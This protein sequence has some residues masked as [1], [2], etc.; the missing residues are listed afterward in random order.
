[1]Q[2]I[3]HILEAV[4]SDHNGDYV[5]AAELYVEGLRS[6]TG[7]A[8]EP[9]ISGRYNEYI[10]RLVEICSASPEADACITRMTAGSAPVSDIPGDLPTSSGFDDL[11]PVAAGPMSEIV[12]HPSI[13]DIT[14][15]VS[16]DDNFLMSCMLD[17]DEPD[18]RE[19]PAPLQPPLSFAHPTHADVPVP[20]AHTTQIASGEVAASSLPWA[21]HEADALRAW[22][23]AQSLMAVC[24]TTR[25]VA[26]MAKRETKL[27][28]ATEA[29]MA[30][31]AAAATV[32]QSA[33]AD[34]PL[35]ADAEAARIRATRAAAAA[36]AQL[37]KLQPQLA[38]RRAPLGLPQSSASAAAAGVTGK[39]ALVV[40]SGFVPG[41]SS[42]RF[43]GDV[44][45]PSD[46]AG[47]RALGPAA[48]RPPQP[49][50]G[51]PPP[52][53]PP[54]MAGG[55]VGGGAVPQTNPLTPD[56]L[57]T[58]TSRESGTVSGIRLPLWDDPGDGVAAEVVWWK[59][60]Q[61]PWADDPSAVA[62]VV[63]P[64]D[65]RISLPQ[66][67]AGAA[68]P[69]QFCDGDLPALA[70][71]MLEARAAWRRPS[72]FL[73]AGVKVTV[74]RHTTADTIVQ[75]VV[76]DCSFVCSV[77]VASHYEGLHGG[78]IL[79]GAIYPQ[80][81]SGRPI[82]SPTGRYA[83]K[84]LVNGATRKV[85]VDD[86][87]PVTDDGR[88]LCTHSSVVQVPSDGGGSDRHAV[89]DL[90]VSLYEKA[91][92][93]VHGNSY[94]FPGSTSSV[95]LY[96]LA[97]WLPEI[98]PL[99]YA[100]PGGADITSAA[101]AAGLPEPPE[102]AGQD[103][104]PPAPFT[105]DAWSVALW[106]RLYA[107]HVRGDGIYTLNTPAAWKETD[108]N[109]RAVDVEKVLGLVDG[110]AYALLEM[111]EFTL[112]PP[113]K[114]AETYRLV[115]VKNP[116]TRQ[117][118]L[119]RFSHRDMLSWPA[120]LAETLDVARYRTEEDKGVF[121]I[122]WSDVCR[123]FSRLHASWNPR[124]KFCARVVRH[125]VLV[126]KSLDNGH[127]GRTSQLH[128]SVHVPPSYLPPGY[129]AALAEA[130]FRGDIPPP[131][132]RTAATS[133]A[134][135]T[136]PSAGAMAAAI[137][138][139]TS[140]VPPI[141]PI[142]PP[143]LTAWLLLSTHTTDGVVAAEAAAVAAGLSNRLYST[144][145]LTDN[146]GR[147][148]TAAAD[149]AR[150]EERVRLAS[151]VATQAQQPADGATAPARG[152]TSIAVAGA[153]A[154]ASLLPTGLTITAPD[155]IGRAAVCG[156]P[157]SGQSFG[158]AARGG[159]CLA[160]RL[161]HPAPAT[162][163][164]HWGTFRNTTHYLVPNI[165]LH[166]GHNDFT[167]VIATS[168]CPPDELRLP[169]TLTLY[170]PRPPPV[171]T[172]G[173]PPSPYLTSPTS[174]IVSPSSPS[175]VPRLPIA[176][177]LH[178]ISTLSFHPFTPSRDIFAFSRPAAP[179]SAALPLPPIPPPEAR[180][181]VVAAYQPVAAAGSD[182]A[183]CGGGADRRG[184]FHHNPQWTVTVP[185]GGARVV[186]S[187]EYAPVPRPRAGPAGRFAYCD[188]V[189][190]VTTR[191]AAVVPPHLKNV[192]AGVAVV[193]CSATESSFGWTHPAAAQ[194]AVVAPAASGGDVAPT[195][196]LG[197]PGGPVHP[198][199]AG[200]VSFIR[201]AMA[202]M[203]GD[204]RL[205]AG[206]AHGGSVETVGVPAVYCSNG[207]RLAVID[208]LDSRAAVWQSVGRDVSDA[209]SAA[210]ASM[211][212]L[213]PG[214][215]TVAA[216]ISSVQDLTAQFIIESDVGVITDGAAGGRV[217]GIRVARI[218]PEGSGA[219]VKGLS[220]FFQSSDASHAP[221]VFHISSEA[222]AIYLRAVTDAL[223]AC[224]AGGDTSPTSQNGNARG[225][226]SSRAGL[227]VIT[228]LIPAAE[229]LRAETNEHEGAAPLP[230]PSTS[231]SVIFSRG[232][233]RTVW[234]GGFRPV[235]GGLT[236]IVRVKGA[237][238]C[239]GALHA[240][241]TGPLNVQHVG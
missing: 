86:R 211:P 167:A 110:H 28:A 31:A 207:R 17:A 149:T 127:W 77:A 181:V 227:T 58:L 117:R 226:S 106:Q 119:G 76:S 85:V 161:F 219:G 177:A 150:A 224:D 109:G 172:A 129:T 46:A 19:L 151:L 122:S 41:V 116:W 80:D 13:V 128:V 188:E 240:W 135:S 95:D 163:L 202:G 160:R 64:N 125:G 206:P 39:G 153:A 68:P 231:G 69:Q 230:P 62:A 222:A 239:I 82:V 143:V 147:A 165:P 179:P 102:G 89:F 234:G 229:A 111:R 195:V 98:V 27:M 212:R 237:D 83:V 26:T 73:P 91:F 130:A 47:A 197:V 184:V 186:V 40:R 178:P 218:P 133:G 1:M 203:R 170:L 48:P 118:W 137:N 200:R 139:P 192:A 35:R 223:A 235:D 78:K 145:H 70:T 180:G 105:R 43:E 208:T 158:G 115:R 189:N 217:G 21:T 20:I 233:L 55:K 37:E 190:E 8:S 225:T 96:A 183:M 29:W 50:E 92:L 52:A 101:A 141:G 169:Y 56:E 90:Y 134:G 168:A 154:A 213:A 155:S 88:I 174:P 49:S 123:Y 81:A 23:A 121:W 87:L 209:G 59:G 53:A 60:V 205:G 140:V 120:E 132:H 100:R 173:A 164:A 191:R 34:A 175:F 238:G 166:I 199:W 33:A 142:P 99:D 94:N 210:A 24:E 162:Y 12:N 65:T 51:G 228:G 185:S 112:S 32:A 6:L 16:E 61:P 44:P 74:G 156:A 157:A 146:T 14:A 196:P 198:P 214:V 75:S 4:T 72:E 159:R 36:I 216:Y 25:D 138:V 204:L 241:A 107:S 11:S 79:I 63:G 201:S 114:A 9:T 176:S 18:H 7:Y 194:A 126:K 187:V 84:L 108:A 42:L 113:G 30:A 152:P 67:T 97:G 5:T 232:S 38:V 15:N 71:A 54:R 221:L 193:P 148:T 182:A 220:A 171:P 10:E 236:V 124:R 93:K 131:T 136:F 3:Q 45:L 104:G 215:Y 22:R 66:A 57:A 144:L 2:A 103:G